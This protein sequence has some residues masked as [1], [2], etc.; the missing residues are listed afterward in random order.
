MVALKEMIRMDFRLSF[1]LNP[2]L[3]RQLKATEANLEKR[4]GESLLRH[5]VPGTEFATSVL[6]TSCIFVVHYPILLLKL[7]D[8]I[9]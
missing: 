9:S 3:F 5:S 7:E 4:A 6:N 1:H 2:G 8:M